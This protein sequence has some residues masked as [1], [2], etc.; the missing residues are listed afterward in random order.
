MPGR[1]IRLIPAT[2]R[3][4]LDHAAGEAARNAVESGI[5][6]WPLAGP[7][8]GRRSAVRP[9]LL[10][11]VS[12]GQSALTATTGI[13]LYIT[14]STA[15]FAVLMY[16]PSRMT[17]QPPVAAWPRV[18]LMQRL[19]LAVARGMPWWTSGEVRADRIPAL[20]A[21]LHERH[22][23]NANLS[24][25][26]SRRIAGLPRSRLFILAPPAGASVEHMPWWLLATQ[27][28]LQGES[29]ENA[30]DRGHRIYMRDFELVRLVSAGNGTSWT[31]RVKPDAWA[32]YVEQGEHL[33]KA[34]RRAGGAGR[35]DPRTAQR[36]ID[37]L[38][39]WPG[40]A[41]INQQRAALFRTMD[42][43]S[44]GTLRIPRFAVPR[45]IRSPKPT[46]PARHD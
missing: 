27:D 6:V 33:A 25:Q 10:R 34:A 4:R 14:A 18:A 41:G 40:M 21:K 44:H 28:K 31:W 11:E 23:A 39:K 7:L 24:E 26:R 5:V 35:P 20:V 13:S 22:G 46:L 8:L 37:R 1:N 30:A 12:T 29:L 45:F 9:A 17:Q 36:F 15:H 43:L 3:S 32:R 2:G 19:A 16:Y 42:A 38:G